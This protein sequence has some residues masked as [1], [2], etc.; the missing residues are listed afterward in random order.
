MTTL[1][2]RFQAIKDALH[3]AINLA[4]P[5]A[6]VR[7]AEEAFKASIVAEVAALHERLDALTAKLEPAAVVAPAAAVEPVAAPTPVVAPAAPVADAAP[8]STE[9]AAPAA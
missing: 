6:A 3:N 9:P 1:H 2:E 8:S 7:E 5:E 4:D